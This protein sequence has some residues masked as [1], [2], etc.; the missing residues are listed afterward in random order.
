MNVSEKTVIRNLKVLRQSFLGHGVEIISTPSKGCKIQIMDYKEFERFIQ[1]DEYRQAFGDDHLN[2]PENRYMEIIQSFLYQYYVKADDL[3]EKL[4][5]SSSTFRSDIKKVKQILKEYDLTL[6]SKPYY[7]MK[8]EGEESNIRNLIFDYIFKGS[9]ENIRSEDYHIKIVL[10]KAI[11]EN[12]QNSG[13]EITNY[14]FENLVTYIYITLIR[15]RRGNTI[16]TKKVHRLQADDSEKNHIASKITDT[17]GRELGMELSSVEEMRIAR[18]MMGEQIFKCKPATTKIPANVDHLVEKMLGTIKLHYQIDFLNDLELRISLGLHIN[19]MLERLK[20]DVLIKNPILEDIKKETFA[21]E[22]ALY[23]SQ[24]INELYCIVVNEHEAGY[25]ALYLS[26]ALIRIN[27]EKDKKNILIICGTG[28]STA[29]FLKKKFEAEFSNYIAGLETCDVLEL[30]KKNLS[31]FDLLV[32]TVPIVIESSTPV[33]QIDTI[34]KNRDAVVIKEHLSQECENKSLKSYFK[35]RLFFKDVRFKNKT[36]LLKWVSQ[37]VGDEKQIDSDL[38]YFE[39]SRREELSSTELGNMIAI[40]H[41]LNVVI[42]ETFLTV[43]ILRE[44]M[45]WDAKKVQ[46]VLL[47]N[48]SPE[49]DVN[50]QIFY[51][52][53]TEFISN[54]E[55]VEKASKLENMRAFVE[56]LL[57]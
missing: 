57:R 7:G 24:I 43:I 14:S 5:I 15:L 48:I 18:R 44:P 26:A 52:A 35:D 2:I 3:C 47:F 13:Y 45:Q 27:Q 29:V 23:S 31:R 22:M 51:D 11:L 33:I 12:I 50:I 42:P 17:I 46:V 40:P 9:P 41:P 53:I 19:R 8:I 10:E 16:D 32:S 37:K 6:V 54:T 20:G 21:Y 56:L 36:E 1:T 55:K 39:L 25:I 28:K 30:K 4:C 49:N 34:L 38:Y